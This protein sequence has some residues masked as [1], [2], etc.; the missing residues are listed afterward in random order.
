VYCRREVRDTALSIWSQHFAHEALA[1]AY[2]FAGIA[3]VE[4]DHVR[5]MQCWRERFGDR[6][7]EIDYEAVV[8]DR[9]AQLRR[10]SD[11]IGVAPGTDAA[12]S[13]TVTT[14]SV[15]QARQPVY[16]RSVGRW[17][18]YAPYVPEL[19]ALAD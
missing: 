4:K 5:F 9:D 12:R 3:Q 11:F 15:W 10:L 2:D 18:S 8:A 14:A 1:F 13:L 19:A 17:K 7:I 6:I 16:A